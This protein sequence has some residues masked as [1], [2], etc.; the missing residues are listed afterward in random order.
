[1]HKN[2]L[3]ATIA[4]TDKDGITTYLQK[5]FSTLNPDLY[6]FRAWLLAHD[7]KDVCI[8]STSKYWIPVFNLLEESIRVILT[9]PKYVRATKGQKTDK[10]DSE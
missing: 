4:T 1:M 7:Y 2:S 8:E 3:V 5:S 10:K 9:H 6:A